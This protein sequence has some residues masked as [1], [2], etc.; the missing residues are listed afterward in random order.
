MAG[1]L[2]IELTGDFHKMLFACFIIC[3]MAAKTMKSFQEGFLPLSGKVMVKAYKKRVKSISK[4]FGKIAKNVKKGTKKLCKPIGKVTKKIEKIGN[5][6]Q[7]II[8]TFIPLASAVVPNLGAIYLASPI[9]LKA[10]SAFTFASN[11]YEGIQTAQC[12]YKGIKKKKWSQ[13]FIEGIGITSLWYG[14]NITKVLEK[15]SQC[16]YAFSN[17]VSTYTNG[18]EFYEKCKDV[19]EHGSDF[20]STIRHFKSFTKSLTKIK[21][22]HKIFGIIFH[23]LSFLIHSITLYFIIRKAIRS[24]K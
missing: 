17:L 18:K 23:R 22:W 11:C 6:A 24:F 3:T 13:V 20:A 4:P 8:N 9:I 19:F 12:V 7:P 15:A 10:Q 2:P 21:T 16:H 1:L 14:F 5:V